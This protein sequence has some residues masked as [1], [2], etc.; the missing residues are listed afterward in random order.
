[1]KENCEDHAVLFHGITYLGATLVEDARDEKSVRKQI[2]D[3]SDEEGG[4]NVTV[5]IPSSADG[6]LKL[7]EPG[8]LSEGKDLK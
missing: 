1:M 6:I 7:L 3:L 4:F 2:E 8:S 5:S